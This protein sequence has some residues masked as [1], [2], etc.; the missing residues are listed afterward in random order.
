MVVVQ[1]ADLEYDPAELPALVEPILAGEADAV[2]G[3]RYLRPG[4]HLPW[5]KFRL[6]V[7]LMNGLVRALYGARI[8]DVNTCYKVVRT[9]LYPRLGLECERFEYCAELTAKLCRLRVPIREVPISYHP[10]SRAEGKKIGWRDARQFA[11]CLAA[12]RVRRITPTTYS[13]RPALSTPIS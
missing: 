2:Y 1:D 4:N 9:D 10:R 13:N 6:A 5:T 12:W 7:H 8:T 11:W 3:S